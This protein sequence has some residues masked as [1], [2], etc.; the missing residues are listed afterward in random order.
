LDKS[1]PEAF[2]SSSTGSVKQ[3]PLLYDLNFESPFTLAIAIINAWAKH[4]KAAFTVT[5]LVLI[6]LNTSKDL[7]FVLTLPLPAGILT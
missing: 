7:P 4:R 2:K 5:I 6:A 3:Y 1:T